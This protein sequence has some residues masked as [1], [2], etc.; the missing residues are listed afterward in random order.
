MLSGRFLAACAV[1]FC[2]GAAS[3]SALYVHADTANDLQTQ[4]DSST[5]QITQLQAEIAQLQTQ[6]NATSQ[7]KQT[8]QNAITALNLNIQKLTASINLT[9]AQIT[10][11]DSQIGTLSG[12]I[13]DTVSKIND[14]NTEIGNS[15]RELDAMDSEPAL[16]TLLT[17]GTLSSYYDSAVTLASLRG[18]L[19]SHINTLSNLK[20]NLQTSKDAA[21]SKRDQLAT[22][23]QNLNDQKQGLAIARNSQSKLLAQTK[24]QESAYQAQIAQKKAQEA[25]FE[26]DLLNYENQL[27]LTVSPGSI[28]R[29]G[30]LLSWPV[31]SPYITQYFGNTNFATQNPQIY[32]G[33]G[34]NAIDLRASPGT[35]IKA[36]QSGVVLGTGNTDLTCPGASYGKWIFIKHNNGL[37]TIYA[38]LASFTVAQGDTVVQGQVIGYS[39]T[40]GYATGP[41]L[42]F[43]VY[44]TSGSEIASFASKSCV[45]KTYTMPVADLSAYLNPLSY[46]PSL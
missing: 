12:N 16:L 31:D 7:Q 33:H 1:G 8:L 36:A 18:D 5:S 15:L 35:P 30:A 41:H 45:G 28:P 27:K 9:Q 32:N 13:N 20:T 10:Q 21:Q 24:N 6:L 39:D 37:S 11:T 3:I 2:I 22:L 34:H 29:A 19:E 25:K 23:Q 26:Q 42:H 14:S 17:G 46:L 43:G 4:I 44:A 38:H 40:T